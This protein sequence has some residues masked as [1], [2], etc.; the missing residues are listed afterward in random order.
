[1]MGFLYEHGKGVHRDYSRALEYYRAAADQGHA[2]AANNL[3]TLYLQG[4]GAP[5][6]IRTALKWYQFSAEHGD[7]VG[8]CNLGRVFT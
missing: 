5:K 2:T 3:A 8:Q 6:D 4:L 7:A 1:M